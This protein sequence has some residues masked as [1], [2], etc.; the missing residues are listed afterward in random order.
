MKLLRQL[1]KRLLPKAK[2]EQEHESPSH[3]PLEPPV[4]DQDGLRTV[5][6]HD[7]LTD[8]RF[9]AAYERG[10]QAAGKDFKWHWRVHVGLW[11]A[12]NAARLEGDFV[13]C[14]VGRGFMSSAIMSYLNW[15]SVAKTF[16][17]LDTFQGIDLRY[18]DESDRSRAIEENKLHRNTGVYADNVD[19]V[20]RN[21]SEW[22][23]VKIIPGT[24]PETLEKITAEKVA[25]LH[26]DMNNA[27]PEVEALSFLWSRLSQHS[28][29]L[30][31]DY[32]FI[33]YERQYQ[34]INSFCL[35]KDIPVVALPTGQG[36]ILKSS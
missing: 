3:F 23:N 34:A 8:P 4:Y 13:E 16:F 30:L 31:D 9:V 11:V 12:A 21:F 22:K 27:V 17:L 2:E 6:N 18:V 7:F 25:Y 24:V 10:I 28:I 33:G 32:A 5:H 19:H 20:S 1:G 29:V 26:L 35:G 36:L 14:G 15:S